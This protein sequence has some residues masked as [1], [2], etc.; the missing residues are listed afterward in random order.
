MI[1]RLNIRKQQDNDRKMNELFSILNNLSNSSTKQQKSSL[2]RLSTNSKLNKKNRL[3]QLFFPTRSRIKLHQSQLSTNKQT[4][5]PLNEQVAKLNQRAVDVRTGIEHSISSLHTQRLQHLTT[6]NE[7]TR[8]LER[9]AIAF[10]HSSS[11]HLKQELDKTKKLSYLF[12]IAIT[13]CCSLFS[14]IIGYMIIQIMRDK[15]IV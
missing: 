12:K 3:I 15:G 7:K 11:K 1:E 4:I 13:L 5:S 6:L 10:E 9:A 2:K 8:D 14:F